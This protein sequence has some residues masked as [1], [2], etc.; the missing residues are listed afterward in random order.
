MDK[1][2]FWTETGEEESF[3]ILEEARLG[4]KSYLLVTDDKDGDG[5]A[6]LLRDD[7]APGSGESHYVPVEVEQEL[8]AVLLLFEDKLEEMG[9]L[10]EE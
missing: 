2:S 4:G 9:I 7:A 3:W 1:I 10:L 5:M 8:S 6:M